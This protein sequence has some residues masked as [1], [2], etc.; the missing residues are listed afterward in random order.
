MDPWIRASDADRECVVEAMREQVGAGRLTLD[1]FSERSA[2]AYRAHTVG[3]LNALTRDLPTAAPAPP[4]TA[5]PA[6]LP[7]LALTVA[8][9][10]GTALLVLVGVAATDSMG[11]MMGHVGSMRP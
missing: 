4:L 6:L 8:L 9:L 3:D 5:R 11:S 7:I 1:E 10:I 2:V